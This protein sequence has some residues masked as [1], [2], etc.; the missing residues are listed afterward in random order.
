MRAVVRSGGRVE[1]E[2]RVPGDKSIAHRWLIFAASAEGR[3]ELSGIPSALD[4]ASTARCMA[5]LSGDEALASWAVDAAAEGEGERLTWNT[6]QPRNYKDEVH[7]EGEGRGALAPPSGPL[8]CGNSGT[9]MRLVSGLVAGCHF[10]TV[11]EGDEALSVRPME[12]IAGPLRLMGASVATSEGHA[13][14]EISGGGLTGIRYATLTPSSQ[15]KGA[16]LLAGLAAEGETT[17]EESAPTRDHTERFL[18][19]VGGPVA[20]DGNSVTVSAWRYPGF[21]GRLPGDP[22]SASFVLAAGALTGG[23]VSVPDIGLNPTRTHFL[24][25]MRRMGVELATEG[26][27]E[28][29]GEPAGVIAVHGVGSGLRGTVVPAAEFPLVH[30]EVAV[31]AAL[32]TAADG[33]TR[34]EGA[35]ELRVKESNRLEGLAD[36]LRGLGAGA[37]VQGDALVVAGGGL[38]GGSAD[39]LRD[40]RLAMA[41]VVAGLSARAECSVDGI[42]WASITFPGFVATMQGLG[43][44]LEV[45]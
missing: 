30:D 8:D 14:L 3:S 10:T 15:V 31:L 21:S 32:A 1:G 33:E 41:F 39:G 36:G 9:T 7:V 35:G 26:T 34:F 20:A 17:V 37:E 4:V 45:S 38:S 29:V 23:A 40:H 6:S 42:E 12:R 19:A 2:V 28:S 43:A 11:L 24:D 27:W 18:R 13:P 44:R 5:A 25:V 16:V 22:S